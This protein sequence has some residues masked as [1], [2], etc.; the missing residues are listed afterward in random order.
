MKIECSQKILKDA[1]NA[2]VKT[3]S[4]RTTMQILEGVLLE[5]SNGILKLTTNDLETGREYT[6]ECNVLEEGK[7]VV[8]KKMFSMIVDKLIGDISLELKN[9]IFTIKSMGSVYNLATMNASEYPRLP[10]FNVESSV[11]LPQGVF[12][13]L[14]RKTSFAVSLDENRPVYTG[15][16]VKIE[17]NILTVVAIDGFRL[18]LKKYLLEKETNDFKAIVPGKVLNEIVSQLKDDDSEIT[19]GINKNKAIFEIGKCI[20]V[21]RLIDGEFLNYSNIIPAE[22]ET[23][24]EVRTKELLEAFERVALFSRASIE[25]DKKASIKMNINMDG[26][27]L[28]C[29]SQT[30]DAKEEVL[31]TISGKQLEIGFNPNYMIEALKCIDE[32]V[33]RLNFLSNIT[34]VTINPVNGNEYIYIVLPVRGR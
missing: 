14:I 16:L 26:I 4:T 9:D 33:I 2:V 19:I 25:K 29:N 24:V 13:D 22:K 8:D 18:A 12:K 27:V 10:F 1:L 21:S 7:T 11:T 32:E 5:A 23:C 15:E 17:N 20:V 3:G 28:S 34:P 31:A 30:G 6:M